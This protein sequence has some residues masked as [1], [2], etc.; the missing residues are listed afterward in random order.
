MENKIENY[1]KNNRSKMDSFIPSDKVWDKINVSMNKTVH[2]KSNRSWL[3]YAFGAS[4][5]CL[6]LYFKLVDTKKEH[7]PFS[8]IANNSTPP[9]Q[10]INPVK[11]IF[12]ASSENNKKLKDIKKGNFNFSRID[13]NSKEHILIDSLVEMRTDIKDVNLLTDVLKN[14][15]SVISSIC[16]RNNKSGTNSFSNSIDTLFDGIKRLEINSSSADINILSDSGNQVSF[17]GDIKLESH[18]IVIGKSNYKIIYERKDSLLKISF[19][20]MPK[21]KVV[22]ILGSVD[23]EAILNFKIPDGIDLT[24]NNSCGNVFVKGLKGKLLQIHTFSGDIIAEDINTNL[25]LESGLGNLT[26]T[27]IK[28]DIKANIGSGDLLITHQEGN[29]EVLTSLGNQQF[30]NISGKLNTQCNSGDIKIINMSG[31]TFIRS[32][33]GNISLNTFK[34]N[35]II[36]VAS[37]NVTGK[38]VELVDSMEVAVMY[39]NINM[40]LLNNINTLSFDLHS[41]FGKINIEKDGQKLE[42]ERRLFLKDGNVLVKCSTEAGIQLYR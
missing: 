27:N 5:I 18:G 30:I 12:I 7:V 24:V 39:G 32:G 22:I 37:G 34:G 15:P 13:D 26:A 42:G 8:Q 6:L 29:T 4:V 28:G 23:R 33:L 11:S 31:N 41:K 19:V 35:P 17:K 1:I 2:N 40:N 10:Q 36:N 25:K 20:N 9:K 38:N 3:K 21:T 16:N 14:Q